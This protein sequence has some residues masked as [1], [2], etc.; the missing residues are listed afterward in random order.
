[1]LAMLPRQVVGV[2]RARVHRRQNTSPCPGGNGT[3]LG[4]FQQFTVLCNTNIDGDVL[5]RLDAFDFTTCV[6][7]CSSFHPKCEGVSFDGSKCTLRA[8][9]RPEAQRR[10]RRSES[11]IGSFPGASS[12]CVTLGGSQQALGTSFT[13]MCGFIIDGND[14]S[15]NFAPTFQDCMGQCAATSDCAALSFDPSQDLGF[16]NC[17]L[18]STVTNS[19]A[20]AADRRTDSAMLGANPPPAA[21]SSANPA[22]TAVPA[23]PST[24]PGIATVP[25]PSPSPSPSA[26]AG[27]G[28]AIFFTPPGGNT[29]TTAPP[30]AASTPESAAPQPS[31][32]TT[33]DLLIAIPSSSI[34][35]GSLPFFFPTPSTTLTS[36]S[37]DTVPETSPDQDDSGGDSASSNAWIAAPVVGSVAAVSYTHLT[38]PTTEE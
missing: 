1:M 38:L 20:V 16:K 25:V 34:T 27:A 32:P 3:T 14:I 19:S 37:G 2:E 33:S 21:S 9:L 13:T 4:T 28:G 17:Y 8:R 5:D 29:P 30:P 10:S 7:I 12:N 22:V 11:A 18:K 31:I 26:G 6:D 36:A 15:Q 35:A 24:D 23:P